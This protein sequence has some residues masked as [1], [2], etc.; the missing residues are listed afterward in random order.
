[1]FRVSL[2]RRRARLRS[3]VASARSWPESPS[4]AARG[5]PHP[6]REARVGTPAP[7]PQHAQHRRVPGTPRAAVIGF[8]KIHETEAKAS[9]R[10]YLTED[11]V[12]FSGSVGPVGRPNLASWSPKF[13]AGLGFRPNQVFWLNQVRP[14]GVLNLGIRMDTSKADS[15]RSVYRRINRNSQPRVAQLRTIQFTPVH[16]AGMGEMLNS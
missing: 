9:T 11:T 2:E 10:W 8:L 4:R 1:M 5:H 12:S 6:P 13:P 3:V 15:F 16:R 14:N 7:P